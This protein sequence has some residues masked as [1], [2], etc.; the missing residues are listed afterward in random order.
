MASDHGI[1]FCTNI[2]QFLHFTLK[3]GLKRVSACIYLVVFIMSL[4]V[5][6]DS[7]PKLPVKIYVSINDGFLLHCSIFYPMFYHVQT[8]MIGCGI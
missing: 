5:C 3:M 8:V 4:K 1:R 2:V 7:F 6:I